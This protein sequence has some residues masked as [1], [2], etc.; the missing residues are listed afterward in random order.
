MLGRLDNS[1]IQTLALQV[2]KDSRDLS[3]VRAPTIMVTRKAQRGG[4][5]DTSYLH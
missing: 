3:R 2:T 5:I 4:F 1:V